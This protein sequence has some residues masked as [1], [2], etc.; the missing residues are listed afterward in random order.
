MREVTG[1]LGVIALVL[2]LGGCGGGSGG[3]SSAGTTPVSNS[4]LAKLVASQSFA[5][6]AATSTATI[7]AKTNSIITSEAIAQPLTITYDLA[8]NSYT[9]STQGRSQ[10]FAPGNLASAAGGVA[11]YTV[12][13]GTTTDQL[14][15]H[16]AS[17]AGYSATAQQYSGLGSWLR[18]TTSGGNNAVSFDVFVYGL[19]TAA[20]AVPRTGQA[21]FATTIYGL[22]TIPSDEARTFQG[23]GRMDVDFLDGLFTASAT[24]SETGLATQTSYGSGVYVTASGKV[25]SGSN[26]FAG[27]L[28]YSGN[29][30]KSTGTLNGE[31]FGPN[32]QELGAS[33][34]T[35]G[36]DGS[37]VSGVIWG[38]QDAQL[39]PVNLSLLQIA[40]DQTFVSQ[41][42]QLL[43]S[44]T[45]NTATT[46]IN[47]GAVTVY[48]KGGTSITPS[49]LPS[50][51]VTSTNIAT[52]SNA[53]FTAYAGNNDNSPITVDLYKQGS[54]NSELALTYMNF[55]SWQGSGGS[56]IA[57]TSWFVYGFTSDPAV[58]A[59][60]TGTA[61]Y[62][63]VAYGTTYNGTANVSTS[64]N[65]TAS[66]TVDFTKS[67][68]S[69]SFGL[70]NTG[71]DY[72]TFNVAGT[73]TSG[74]V[75]PGSVTGVTAGSGT[76]A[77]AF[78]G[79]AA[80]EFGGPFTITIPS[81][82]TT[83]VGVTAAKTG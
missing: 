63:G 79:P 40:A 17:V 62:T 70:K 1:R 31:F 67:D 45:S 26:A 75:N 61:T 24:G 78:Y 68:Y 49:A 73:I 2:A 65:G 3:V 51:T 16:A 33:F 11:S 23:V 19:D 41:G 57:G 80:K 34:A 58:V 15:L 76:I 6:Q 64:V 69:G 77:P 21:S 22:V 35:V 46:T 39:P 43:V 29:T 50:V 37:S 55:G 27:D 48:A 30:S 12:T 18:T 81:T 60:K 28:T 52:S 14:T 9:V 47:S 7:V 83:I 20:S 44:Q 10:T 54:A 5:N 38:N 32:A 8:S 71:T 53:N 59:A 13:A 74:V 25:T 56:N 72:G 82:T 4:S 36:H 66:F 42:A